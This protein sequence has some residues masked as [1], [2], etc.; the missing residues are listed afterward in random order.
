VFLIE[1]EIHW[2]QNRN[3]NVKINAKFIQIVHN[4]KSLIDEG[5]NYK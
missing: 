1:D 4:K 3:F 2:L 5:I